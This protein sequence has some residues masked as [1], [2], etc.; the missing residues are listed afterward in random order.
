[1]YVLI[2]SND[3]KYVADQRKRQGSSY[4]NNLK[5]AKIY[6]SRETAENDRCKENEHISTV[7]N[8][9]GF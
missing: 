2:R 9:I 8:E 5:Y 4:T 6:T 7:E 1:M 3:G